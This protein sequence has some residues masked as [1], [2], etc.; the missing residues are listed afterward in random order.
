MTNFAL[1]HQY[2]DALLTSAPK[3]AFYVGGVYLIAAYQLNFGHMA[4]RAHRFAPLLSV[5]C[6]R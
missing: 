2:S 5:D 4:Q 3:I 6:L 1:K